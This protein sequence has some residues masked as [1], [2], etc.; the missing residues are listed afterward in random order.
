[1]KPRFAL[2]AIS[3][4]AN[5]AFVAD[6]LRSRAS[7]DVPPA[8]VAHANVTRPAK[9]A[10]V[11]SAEL[12]EA[13]KSNNPVRLRDALR[14]AGLPEATIRSLVT[15]LIANPYQE[16]WLALRPKPDP[17]QPW[18]K[19]GPNSWDWQSK[20]S[21]EQRAELRTHERAYTNEVT[22]VLGPEPEA[23]QGAKADFLSTDKRK[24]VA[25]IEADYQDLR[26]EVNQ[27]MRNFPL[28]ADAEKLKFIMAEK[29]RDLAAILTPQELA[30]YELRSSDAAEKLH[31]KISKFDRTEEEY[32]NIFAIQKAYDDT[33]N[34]D[35]WGNPID[36]SSEARRKQREAEKIVGAQ[37]KAA[38]G[39]E[40]Y[41]D[42]TRSQNY[43]YQKLVAA[44]QRLSLPPETARQVYDLR[45]TVS[46]ESARIVDN[47]DLGMDQKK[48]L[49]ADLAKTTRSQIR[50]RLGDT[51]AEAYLKNSMSWISKVE[52]G[53]AVTFGEE[54][55]STS[56]RSIPA[57]K[58]PAAA[59]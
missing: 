48:Q 21:R 45:D 59:K 23:A 9:A 50:T 58:N 34:L 37:I 42:Y 55:N 24:T 56:T 35:A 10:S 29:K 16:R 3:L 22:R 4:L 19:E 12:A 7:A 5:A 36:Q 54:G 17:N 32:R 53:N 11:T 13:F 28:P 30:D 15:A 2:L 38:L 27:D 25:E 20:L 8:G 26:E 39:A 43:D 47:P 52:S 46:S 44:T 33:Q 14:A 51:A 49:L 40:R 18:W 57:S 41:A 1:M 31:R 6:A